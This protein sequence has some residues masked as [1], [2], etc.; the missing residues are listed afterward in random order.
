MFFMPIKH[1]ISVAILSIILAVIVVFD[2]TIFFGGAKTTPPSTVQ[3]P[4]S[5]LG[6]SSALPA[7]Q[8]LPVVSP[9][10][11]TAPALAVVSTIPEDG[12]HEV[13]LDIEDPITVTLNTSAQDSFVEFHFEPTLPVTYENNPDKTVFKILPKQALAGNVSYTLHIFS[14]PKNADASAN[15]LLKTITFTAA[16]DKPKEA[17]ALDTH[18]IIAVAKASTVPQITTGKYIDINLATQV[19]ILFENG[20]A[21]DAY[22]ISS[23]KRGMET[24][25]GQ[26]KIENKANRPWS[27]AYNL[28]MP[29]WMAIVPSGKFGIHELPEWPSGYK[30]GANHLGTPVSHGCVRLGVG[31]AKRVFDWS[32]LG[33]PVI[34]Y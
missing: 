33:T 22:R 2:A 29:N 25:K 30:E 17:V 21:L 6:A 20:V 28:Y 10:A 11:K 32:E 3:Q 27:K 15:T 23:G 12:A 9:E 31:P 14:R 1:R 18:D 34:I 7:A 19:M 8:S 5:L 16:P 24:P 13:V 4:S 26:F